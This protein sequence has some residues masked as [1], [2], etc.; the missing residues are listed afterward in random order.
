MGKK[1]KNKTSVVAENA[2]VDQIERKDSS[3]DQDQT[4]PSAAEQ[5][6]TKSVGG[7]GGDAAADITVEPVKGEAEE[8]PTGSPTEE[9]TSVNTGDDKDVKGATPEIQLPVTVSEELGGTPARS[10]KISSQGER[11]N[12]N[13]TSGDFSP[14]ARTG[15]PSP[16][17]GSGKGRDSQ[18]GSQMISSDFEGAGQHH[19]IEI[20]RIEKLHA[21][22]WPRE[23][24]GTFYSGDSYIILHTISKAKK[25]DLYFWLGKESSAD[26]KGA[27]ALKAVELDTTLGDVPVQ[28]RECEGYESGQFLGVFK[29]YG[30]IKYLDGGVD[31][32]FHHVEPDS[33]VP[34]L[35][36]VKG[37]RTCRVKEVEMKRAS[38]NEGRWK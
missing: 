14:P 27:C 36:H 5:S 11:I 34:K 17:S 13:D 16:K 25:Y 33:Y 19:G 7:A 9:S 31:S 35:L 21:V 26:E 4:R 3:D 6:P 28:F 23:L 38:M 12:P 24:F 8:V 37:K 15:S 20:W 32:A 2:D 30:G 10:P 1:K 18:M 29:S 22:A